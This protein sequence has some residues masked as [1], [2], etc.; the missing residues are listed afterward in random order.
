MPV[1]LHALA[2]DNY[3]GVGQLQKLGPF[4]EFNF[5]IGANNAGKSTI[6]DF[7]SKYLQ[8]PKEPKGLDLHSGAKG[9]SIRAIGIP[10][11]IFKQAAETRLQRPNRPTD[12]RFEKQRLAALA[13]L[14]SAL[15][16]NNIIWIDLP[17]GSQIKQYRAQSII[18]SLQKGAQG[19]QGAQGAMTTHEL[20]L[21]WQALGPQGVGA[22]SY[23]QLLMQILDAML[24]EQK[25]SF[26][27][28]SLIP[29][30]RQIGPKSEEFS[31]LSGRGLIDRLAEIQSPDHD[32]REERKLFDSINQFIQ[33]V[34]GRAG[35]E[36][37]VPHNREHILVHMD[38]KILPI[39]SL[40]TGIHEVIMIAAFCTLHQNEIVCMEEPEIHL[41]PLLQRKLVKYLQEQTSNQYFIAT[42]SASFID[43]PEAAIF[44]VFNDGTQTSFR[45]TA[46]RNQ[47]VEICVDLGT[48]ASDILQANA[49]LWVEGPS[50]RLYLQN[51]I[52]QAAPQFIEGVHYSVMFY[53]GR[54]LSHLSADDDEI[55]EFISLRT[56]NQNLA[57]LMDSDR[58]TQE[59]EI[60]KTKQ[61]IQSEFGKGSGVAW[62]TMGRE[63]ENYVDPTVLHEA[64]KSVAGAYGGP[65]KTGQFDH[66]LY[67]KREGSRSIETKIDKVKVAKIVSAQELSLDI[68]DLRERISKLVNLIKSANA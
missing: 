33:S 2:L 48:R 26:P 45:E 12:Q 31:D 21:L 20:Q 38:Q 61:R 56:L 66:A 49:V 42:H 23:S 60:N 22:H 25:L 35:A 32:K 18:A 51:W 27:P 15:A 47:K 10:L 65:S 44:H 8:A 64:I 13:A 39:S 24:N 41:H 46:L 34:T 55:T 37:E 62:V 17:F 19:A 3:R 54:L 67:Y 9:K 11:K 53:G 43:T 52:R 6:L 68:L 57:I 7:L 14:C 50:D 5:F 29:A 36:I 28:V 40:G 16:E 59:S 30:F 1:F 58:S 4:R 63:I